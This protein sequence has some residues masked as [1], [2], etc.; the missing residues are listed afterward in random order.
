MQAKAEESRKGER[1][2]GKRKKKR[3]EEEGGVKSSKQLEEQYAP[4]FYGV[5]S[6]RPSNSLSVVDAVCLRNS[7]S[8]VS[9]SKNELVLF[10]L[11]RWKKEA[12]CQDRY[13]TSLD[14]NQSSAVAIGSKY[15]YAA[16]NF[17]KTIAY[18]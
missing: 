12:P 7:R 11:K 5:L 10:D 2:E 17:E 14:N 3:K 1:A 6:L 4:L 13:F 8:L 15:F 9:N 18:Y 16:L